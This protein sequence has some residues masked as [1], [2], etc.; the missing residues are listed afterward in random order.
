MNRCNE[1]C[2]E[3]VEKSENQS[4]KLSIAFEEWAWFDETQIMTGQELSLG[5]FFI[6]QEDV[7]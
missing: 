1:E 6:L 5:S 3:V 4:E 7:K 2:K